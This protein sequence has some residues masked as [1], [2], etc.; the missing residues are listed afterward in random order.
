MENFWENKNV[1]ITGASGFIGSWLSEELIE[2][3]AKVIA[4]DLRK[5]LLEESNNLQFVE[6]DLLNAKLVEEVLQEREIDSVFH[7][8]SQSIISASIEKPFE[9]FEANIKGTWNLLEACRKNGKIERIVLASSGRI[10][11][12]SPDKMLSDYSKAKLNPY[13]CSKLCI[14]LI[15]KTYADCYGL[16]IGITRC[17]NTFGGRDLNFER[18]I[19]STIKKV[20]SGK[21]P[22]V[23]GERDVKR[24]F[25]YIKDTVNAYVLL[26][27][28]LEKKDVKGKTFN[29]SSGKTTSIKGLAEKIIEL[30]GKKLKPKI[31][32][33]K[34][35]SEIEIVNT[36]YSDAGRLL[37]WKPLYSL[38][39]GLKE[40]IDWYKGYF[41]KEN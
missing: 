4:F 23:Y 16:N 11:C 3:K 36:D 14:E 10:Y 34:S 21:E 13:D 20:L 5:G 29:F 22:V 40:T 7:L 30:S 35:I 15:G 6:G 33:Q 26:A 8:A 27:Q 24:D 2:R 37:G 39:K 38:E 12:N 9:T 18:L 17:P 19:P 32:K 41:K 25:L 31:L 1:L 28:N